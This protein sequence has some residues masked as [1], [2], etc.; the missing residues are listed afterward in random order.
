M[1]KSNVY[2]EIIGHTQKEKIELEKNFIIDI[3]DLKESYSNWFKKYFEI[4][5][6]TG[7]VKC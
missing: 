7:N 2:Y 6:Q 4:L 3:K 5:K 1:D